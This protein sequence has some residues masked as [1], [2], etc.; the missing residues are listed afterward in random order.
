FFSLSA[1][2]ELDQPDTDI[3]VSVG[4]V[5]PDGSFVMLSG[6][7]L[8][9]RY[10]HDL[11]KPQPVRPGAI[12]RYDFDEFMFVARRIGKGSR[13]RLNIAPVNSMYAEKNYNTGGV[14]AEE[15][16]KDARTVTVKLYHDAARPS[17]L[18]VP[19]AAASSVAKP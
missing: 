3:T 19:I 9:A 15:S 17:A 7:A 4:E 8:R 10:R 13:L 16:G 5:K 6:S 12:E 2:I 11:R 14:V 18:T 1:W